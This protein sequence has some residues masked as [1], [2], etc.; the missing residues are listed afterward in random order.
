MAPVTGQQDA[1]PNQRRPPRL[2]EGVQL[3]F[4]LGTARPSATYHLISLR[5]ARRSS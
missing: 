1:E 5:L 3:G 4:Q 2:E